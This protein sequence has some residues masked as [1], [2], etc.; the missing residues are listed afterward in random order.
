[1]GI[2]NSVHVFVTGD[3]GSNCKKRYKRTLVRRYEISKNLNYKV[4]NQLKNAGHLGFNK[5]QA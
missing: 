3:K 5:I 1:M 4:T 2:Q